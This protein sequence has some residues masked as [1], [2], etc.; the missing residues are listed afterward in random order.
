MTTYTLTLID[1]TGIQDY[2]FFS[3]RLQENIGASELVY[4]ATNLWAFEVL[5]EMIGEDRHN[6]LNHTGLEWKYGDKRIEDGELEAE[7]VQAAGGNL[8]ILFREH[9]KAIEFVQKLTLKVL[10]KAPGITLL[11]QH[12]PE[13]DFEN[14]PLGEA[15]EA[16]SEMMKAHKLSRLPSSPLLGLGIT[17]A[18]ASTG[19]PAVRSSEGKQGEIALLVGDQKDKDVEKSRLISRE[20]TF[21]LVAREWA[22]ARLDHWLEEAADG[23]KFPFDLD[24]L[25]RIK[26]EDSY[27]AVVHVDGN[28]MGDHVQKATA[29]TKNNRDWIKK[30]REFSQ[31]IHEAN[32]A[33]LHKIVSL[34]AHTLPDGDIP[35]T[36][37]NGVDYLPFR[38]LVFGGD[39]LTFVCNG[40][41]GVSLATMYIEEF[42]E[43][44]KARGLND[45]Y[46]SAG[47]AMV[48][49]HY[50][51]ARAYKL[52]EELIKSAKSL[53]RDPES[54][55]SAIDWHFAQS[56]LS[57]S[58]ESI[59]KREY[60]VDAGK[61]YLRPL[62]LEGGEDFRSWKTV[63]AVI[64]DFQKEWA[65]NKAIGL[66]E[67][68]RKEEDAKEYILNF[69]LGKK[70]PVIEGDIAL[71][72]GWANGRC[73][74]F[75]AIE[76]M[77]H[78]VPIKETEEESE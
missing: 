4:R 46:A 61:L 78:Y 76:L 74:Y 17:A 31:M 51:F 25:G 56:G 13:F 2:I 26:G 23:Y 5:H 41:I 32:L 16:L 57:G 43:A 66:R 54:D 11:A 28:H 20:T 22:N 47:V 77:D 35:C 14:K 10:Q 45:L 27:L 58:L 52:S 6:I 53:N 34:L 68:L 70:M 21:K 40:K 33:A 73:Y 48:K 67:P 15:R 49:M 24:N 7:V 29:N 19:L 1:T 69:G 42:H 71:E 44:A 60:K 64:E 63:K 59:R 38:P 3:N 55:C 8:L 65:H 12:L 18:C 36:T 30:L 62:T 9:Q 37:K 50:P 39:D 75:D 72:T